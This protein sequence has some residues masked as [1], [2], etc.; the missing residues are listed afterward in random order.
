VLGSVHAVSQAVHATNTYRPR[1]Q[2]RTR[3]S[4][5]WIYAEGIHG[6]WIP[7]VPSLG[8]LNVDAHT[9]EYRRSIRTTSPIGSLGPGPTWAILDSYSS[10]PPGF[11]ES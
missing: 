3:P 2:V 9:T 11:S 4:Y 7:W 6:D 10:P 5:I 1:F 8:L